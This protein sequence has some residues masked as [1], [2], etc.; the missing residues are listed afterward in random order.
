MKRKRNWFSSSTVTLQSSV[1]I[2]KCQSWYRTGVY[3]H[4]PVRLIIFKNLPMTFWEL[5]TT[6][7]EMEQYTFL[8]R[9]QDQKNTDHT[10]SYLTHFIKNCFPMWLKRVHLF[11]D[12]AC[13]TNKNAFAWMSWCHTLIPHGWMGQFKRHQW[14]YFNFKGP[15]TNNNVQG[16]HSRLKKVWDHW[17]LQEGRSEHKGEN[18]DD[19]SWST[20]GPKTK[21][22]EA[23]GETNPELACSIQLWSNVI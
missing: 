8:M 23:K 17:C 19:G 22:G 18:A 9:D 1:Q 2:I 7:K 11:L 14:N 13:S 20:A 16:L 12:N 10:V 5:L 3:L 6:E 4:N 21:T 15:R